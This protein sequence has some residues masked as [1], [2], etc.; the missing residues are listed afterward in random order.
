[1]RSI[2]NSSS[3]VDTLPLGMG[4]HWRTV[5]QRNHPSN[6]SQLTLGTGGQESELGDRKMAFSV[7]ICEQVFS[8]WVT[9]AQPVC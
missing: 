4:F 6:H 7:G 5:C 1:M 8:T 2:V 3:L 9:L